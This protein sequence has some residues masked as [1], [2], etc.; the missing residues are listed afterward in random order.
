VLEAR[1]AFVMF[2]GPAGGEG[3]GGAGVE[4]D[5]F[6][7]GDAGGCDGYGACHCWTEGAGFEFLLGGW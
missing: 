5:A 3:V 6:F 2:D 7:G 4:E 1:G